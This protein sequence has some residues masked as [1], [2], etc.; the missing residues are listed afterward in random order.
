MLTTAVHLSLVFMLIQY[1]YSL[2][3]AWPQSIIQW[4]L[5]ERDWVLTWGS[6][7]NLWLER[8][9]WCHPMASIYNQLPSGLEFL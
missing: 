2:V 7:W 1:I 6:W 4:R 8:A 3:P 9:H 5:R